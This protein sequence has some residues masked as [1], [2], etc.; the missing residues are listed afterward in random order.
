MD[1]KGTEEEITYPSIFFTIDNF[2]EV[3]FCWLLY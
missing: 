1:H 2:E 3:S